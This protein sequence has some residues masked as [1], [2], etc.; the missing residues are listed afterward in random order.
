MPPLTLAY[1]GLDESG[2]LPADTPLF[3][4][5][6]VLTYRPDAIRNLIRRAVVHSGKRLKRPLADFVAGSV[7]AWHKAGDDTVKLIESKISVAIVEDWPKIKR[8]WIR[9]EK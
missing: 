7:Y 3:T 4:L 9:A 8:R 5:A 2:S 6:G 1:L